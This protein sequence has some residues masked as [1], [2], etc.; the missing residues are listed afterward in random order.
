MS[1]IDS[2]YL[3]AGENNEN[4]NLY[5]ISDINDNLN[6]Y[7]DFNQ[8][9]NF[10]LVSNETNHQNFTNSN[11]NIVNKFDNDKNFND[12]CSSNQNI[13]KKNKEKRGRKSNSTNKIK[14]EYLRTK[15]AKDNIIR[16][17][18]THFINNFLLNLINVLISEK[19]TNKYIIR[20]IRNEI[21][22]DIT[23]KY[24][25]YLFNQTLEQLYSSEI[26]NQF[27]SIIRKSAN[28]KIINQ[29]KKEEFFNKFLNI[30]VKDIYNIYINKNCKEI[31]K[32]NYDIQDKNNKIIT[33]NEFIKK[34]E[35]EDVYYFNSINMI[36]ENLINYF[37]IKKSRK[38][39]KKKRYKY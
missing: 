29:I 13:T 21:S 2:K 9:E 17:I 32:K 14:N 37:Q 23:I 15:F 22:K 5:L 25:I 27:K 30:K 12:Y 35:Q 28:K 6:S 24:N 20:K 19:I 31:L 7:G 26:S 16:K 4:N 11:G 8:S 18:K 3:Y 39:K 1:I 38:Y 34:F 36:S 10:L 33:F